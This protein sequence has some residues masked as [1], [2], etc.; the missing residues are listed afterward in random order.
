[1]AIKAEQPDLYGR[2]TT[3]PD[4]Y[5]R[6]TTFTEVR[7]RPKSEYN[8]SV[9]FEREHRPPRRTVLEHDEEPDLS[10]PALLPARYEYS[11]D[12]DPYFI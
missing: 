7:L 11:D 5:G 1:V 9:D 12:F 6:S 3:K 4:L 2:S 8:R 10:P